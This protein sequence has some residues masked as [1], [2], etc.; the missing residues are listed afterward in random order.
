ILYNNIKK[1]IGAEIPDQEIRSIILALGITSDTESAEGMELLVPPYKVDVTRECDITEE[2]LRIYGYNNIQ[3]PSKVN[4]S[5]S[6]SIRPD[7]ENTQHTVADMLSSNGFSEIWCNSLTRASYVIDESK[8][9]EIL[10]PLSSD[11]GIMRQSLLHPAL[12]SVA[13]NQNRKNADLKFYEFGKIYNLDNGE[14]KESLRL[15]LIISGNKQAEQWNQNAK[16]VDFYDLKAAV[17]GLIGRLGISGLQA[18]KIEGNGFGY[19]IKYFRGDKDIVRLGSVAETDKKRTGVEREV[20]YADI[21]WDA[22][23][24]IVSKNKIK[25]KEVPKFPSV[26][27]DL[28]MLVDKSVTFDSLKSIAFK[29]DRKLVKDVKIFDVFEGGGK[30]ALP[31]GKKSYALNFTLQNEEQTLTDKQI[32]AVMQKIIHNLAQEVNAEIRK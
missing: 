8:V 15:L 29:T 9:V 13:Y 31:E 7:K 19:G 18:E 20:F 24:K 10:N 6:N 11:L 3:I 26:R 2:V 27:R 32:D 1:L 21:D 23:L 16:P 12:E 5:L 14:Y 22:V 25:N 4:A 30:T 28:S 17:D